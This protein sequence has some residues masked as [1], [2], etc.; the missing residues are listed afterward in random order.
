MEERKINET[1][2]L[3][4]IS[5]M[6]KNARTNLRAK[7]N[8]NI[9]LLWGYA[10]VI[11]SILVWVLKK[12]TI[13]P[14]TSLLWLLI[15]FICLPITKY[16]YSKDKVKVKSYLDKTID[17]ITILNVSVCTIIALVAIWVKM[18]VLFI[19]GILFSMWII[20]IGLLIRYR[21]VIYG[22][23][24]GIILSL[25]LLFV[26][27]EVNQ[28]LTFALIPLFSIIIPGHLFKKNIPSNV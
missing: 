9:L 5:M 10:V 22:G 1:D 8:S 25:C 11:I 13:F 20:I 4:L 3:K 21:P 23:V 12:W 7:I 16:L 24:I 17:Y 2:S 28:I 27:E 19:E 6:V 18:P 26:P 14:Y 15:P